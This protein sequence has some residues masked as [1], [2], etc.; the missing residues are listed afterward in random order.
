MNKPWGGCSIC[1]VS[2]SLKLA[3][4]KETL[5]CKET[6]KVADEEPAE[7][8]VPPFSSDNSRNRAEHLFLQ[9]A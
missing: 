8:G 5:M 1:R 9:T 2:Q 7:T 6:M 4:R 3:K